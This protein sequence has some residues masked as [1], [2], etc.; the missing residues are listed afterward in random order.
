M[1]RD[2][3]SVRTARTC[4]GCHDLDTVVIEGSLVAIRER[5]NIPR[6]YGLHISWPGRHP[7]SS[8]V[9]GVCISV[10]A[11]ETGLHHRGVPQVV[12]NLSE[13]GGT[14]TRGATS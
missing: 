2:R 12:G 3:D 5:Y 4:P 13:S 9:P 7:Y 1:F 14:P 6:E 11:L 8:D 10:D